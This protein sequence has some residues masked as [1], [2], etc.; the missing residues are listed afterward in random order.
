MP[1]FVRTFLQSSAAQGSRTT[2]LGPMIWIVSL[3]AACAVGTSWLAQSEWAQ[4]VVIGLLIF[5]C[6]AFVLCYVYFMLRNP[7]ALRSEKFVIEKAALEQGLVG[8]SL[9]GLHQLTVSQIRNKLLEKLG[10]FRCIVVEISD[11]ETWAGWI[12]PT[13]SNL[14]RSGLSQ[15][16]AAQNNG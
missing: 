16:G 13:R 7:D 10:N 3:I 5:V 15:A 1:D 11:Q 9:R 4:Y 2:V 14:Q 12:N 8:D 6:L